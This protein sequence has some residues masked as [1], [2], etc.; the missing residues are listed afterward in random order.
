MERLIIPMANDGYEPTS[1]MGNDTV[2][3][4]FSDKPQRLFNYFRQQF[5]Q[6]TNPP[7]DPIREELVMS[8]T[9]FIGSINQNL[10]EAANEIC[11]M[12]KLKSPV[13]T[14]A[15]FDILMNLKYKGFSTISLPM[16]FD[17]KSGREGMEKAIVYRL[18]KQ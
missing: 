1:S 10:L 8:L 14:N 6:V 7:I 17:P 2:L 18:K 13:L 16:L 4:V 5:A 12:V 9:G 15:Q 11:K 3:S